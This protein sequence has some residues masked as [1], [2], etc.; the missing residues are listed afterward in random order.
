MF[1]QPLVLFL[2]DF[3]KLVRTQIRLAHITHN[4][5]RFNIKDNR[6]QSKQ[7]TLEIRRGRKELSIA[8]VIVYPTKNPPHK[9]KGNIKI[10]F[11]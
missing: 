8:Q 2:A 7:C 11:L 1:K 4:P 5:V 9:E 6:K 10:Q 3:P